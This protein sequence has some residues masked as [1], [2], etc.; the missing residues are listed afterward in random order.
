MHLSSRQVPN[1]F[2]TCGQG[3]EPCKP[4][5]ARGFLTFPTFLTCFL[6]SVRPRVHACTCTCTYTSI[7]LGRLGRLGRVRRSKVFRVPNLGCWV[8][9]VGKGRGEMSFGGLRWMR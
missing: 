6:A 8:G 1:L 7:R 9:K 3:R 2:P 5:A 4:C